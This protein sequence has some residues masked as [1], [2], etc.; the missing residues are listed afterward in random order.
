M[1]P[2]GS[3]P[4]RNLESVCESSTRAVPQDVDSQRDRTVA[5]RAARRGRG[6]PLASIDGSVTRVTNRAAATRWPLPCHRASSGRKRADTKSIASP[7]S[8]WCRAVLAVR[9]WGATHR[10]AEQRLV[11]HR[12]AGI[13]RRRVDLRCEPAQRQRI[14]G[15]A[16]DGK[17]ERLGVLQPLFW[18]SEDN[19]G[20]GP[21]FRHFACAVRLVA[22]ERHAND[23]PSVGGPEPGASAVRAKW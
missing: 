4:I 13:E 20:M 21:A 3:T 11:V 8:F 9:R 2:Q 17:P 6:T 16:D 18:R 7:G 14:A 23:R 19:R 12:H 1:I 22:F 15:V 10:H 5:H